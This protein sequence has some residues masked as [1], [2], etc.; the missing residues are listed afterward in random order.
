MFLRQLTLP[1]HHAR[2]KKLILRVSYFIILTSS[3]LIA[4]LTSDL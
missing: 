4:L 1:W 2:A 3:F